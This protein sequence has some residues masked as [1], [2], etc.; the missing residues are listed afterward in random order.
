MGGIEDR[1]RGF[2]GSWSKIKEQ[3]EQAIGDERLFDGEEGG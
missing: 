3:F 1:V 2:L